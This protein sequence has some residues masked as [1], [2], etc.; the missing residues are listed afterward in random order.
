MKSI[1]APAAIL[2][3]M[4]AASPLENWTITGTL[5]SLAVFNTALMVLLPVTLTPR[6]V[7]TLI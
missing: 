4:K 6:E 5:S 1:E 7:V 2:P 3:P